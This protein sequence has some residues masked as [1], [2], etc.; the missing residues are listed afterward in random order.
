[1]KRRNSRLAG[2][3][4]IAQDQ[5]MEKMTIRVMEVSADA[6]LVNAGL[7]VEVPEIGAKARIEIRFPAPPGTGPDDWREEAY[8]RALMMLDPA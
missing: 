4:A 7:S 1:M 2:C 6:G 8:D 3:A 5:A